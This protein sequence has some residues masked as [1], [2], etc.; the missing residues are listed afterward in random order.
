MSS[1]FHYKIC[2]SFDENKSVDEFIDQYCQPDSA[3]K[4]LN[5]TIGYVRNS[6]NSLKI[7]NDITNLI[8][9]F[10]FGA[11]TTIHIRYFTDADTYYDQMITVP[12]HYS[13]QDIWAYIQQHFA[14][15]ISNHESLKSIDCPMFALC[16]NLDSPYE[17]SQ[18]EDTTKKYF[19][20][21][22]HHK[23]NPII[24]WN[25]LQSN[26]S[27]LS[28]ILLG[29]DIL[30]CVENRSNI[31]P[32]E[33]RYTTYL[34]SNVSQY[35]RPQTN[36]SKLLIHDYTVTDKLKYDN[37]IGSS[38][39]ESV[40]VRKIILR[41]PK[42]TKLETFYDITRQLCKIPAH[43]EVRVFRVYEQDKYLI[44]FPYKFQC[45]EH[46]LMLERGRYPKYV[47]VFLMVCVINPDYSTSEFLP[48][49][50]NKTNSV[51]RLKQ[52]IM[53]LFHLNPLEYNKYVC[54]AINLGRYQ[55]KD[56]CWTDSLTLN[57]NLINPR[58]GDRIGIKIRPEYK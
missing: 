46:T 7:P 15:N 13:L 19:A 37:N 3:E 16:S 43:E 53:K 26:W 5:I 12:M 47:E 18:N 34:R 40:Q 25:K 4:C 44:T 39:A 49:I 9:A 11:Y 54:Y 23:L 41:I 31:T 45:K 1:E 55:N 28:S 27:K 50:I 32:V 52:N 36:L 42:G 38:H 56:K 24:V 35:Y 20:K 21:I 58:H 51:R 6:S 48:L 33:H 57:S 17:I 30:L 29:E 14:A 8:F 2:D 10:H 22:L